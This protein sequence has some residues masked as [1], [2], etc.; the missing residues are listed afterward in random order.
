MQMKQPVYSVAV[1]CVSDLVYCTSLWAFCRRRSALVS[2][3]RMIPTKRNAVIRILH[4]N[5]DRA[6]ITLP[7]PIVIPTPNTCADPLR[8]P[9]VVPS[10]MG[11]VSSAAN[12]KPIGKYPV[13][14]NP[15][16]QALTNTIQMEPTPMVS[17]K[18]S[19]PTK[20]KMYT[21]SVVPLIVV[22]E[23]VENIAAYHRA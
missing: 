9:E 7:M 16:R 8:S 20:E 5:V 3:V 18:L 2:A 11:K 23:F 6:Y 10:A 15:R 4:Q 21:T 19:I 17:V 12:S 22:M 13:I 14:K 1:I